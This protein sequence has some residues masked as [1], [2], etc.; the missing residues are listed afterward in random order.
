[1]SLEYVRAA[2]LKQPSLLKY[3]LDSLRSKV[4]FLKHE[5]GLSNE[6]VAK[7]A[8]SAPAVLGLSLRNNLR[9]KVAILMKLGSLSQFEVGEMVTI[10]P[11]ILLLSQKNKIGEYVKL[12][13]L[14][15]LTHMLMSTAEPMISYIVNEFE[16]IDSPRKLGDLILHTPHILVRKFAKHR[17]FVLYFSRTDTIHLVC[18]SEAEPTNRG[19]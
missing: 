12:M 4:D 14:D 8:T 15:S 2:V 19:I 18:T 6:A 17:W 13:I 16:A 5:I 9:P 3:G 10:S 1:M 7:L 11:H